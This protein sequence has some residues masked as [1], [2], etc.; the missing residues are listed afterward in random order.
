MSDAVYKSGFIAV[1]GRPNTG[2]STLVNALVG[3]TISVVTAKAQTTRHSI[4]GILSQSARQFVFVDTPGLHAKSAKLINR[5]MNKSA[6]ASLGGADVALFV[7]EATGWRNAD[8]LVHEKVVASGVPTLL[9]VNKIDRIKP[10]SALLPVLND[11]AVRGDFAEIIP[12]SALRSDNLDRL[13]DVVENYLPESP[14]LFAAETV[15]DRSEEFRVSEILR[16]RLMEALHEEVPYGL[17]VEV[18]MLERRS[19]LALIDAIIWVDK[20]SHKG[21]VVGRGGERLKRVNTQARHDLEQVFGEHFYLQVTVKVK[22]NWSDNAAAL[23]QLG[24]EAPP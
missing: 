21:I 1:V 14:P 11:F 24:Y 12:V 8:N 3:E 6:I 9:V 5:A 17:A 18:V 13:L 15:T 16:G 23:R 10:K 7:V 4:L 20:E 2:K 19:E 22:G